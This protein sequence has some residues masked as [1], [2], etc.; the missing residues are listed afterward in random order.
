M[1]VFPENMDKLNADDPHG[2]FSIIENYIRYMTERTEFAMRNMTRTVSSAGISTAEV[3][4]LLTAIQND[5]SALKS[6]VNGLYGSVTSVS[7]QVTALQNTAQT[8][9]DSVT[10]LDSAVK[11]LSDTVS[12]LEQRVAALEQTETT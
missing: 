10:A 7:G 1:A 12:S 2:S 11:D 8:L 3:Y 5:L 4:I 9:Q 6:T